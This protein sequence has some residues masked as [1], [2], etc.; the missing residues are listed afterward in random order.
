MMSIRFWTLPSNRADGSCS[1]AFSN[2]SCPWFWLDPIDL[3]VHH[4]LENED[5]FMC[6][7]F[8]DFG[9]FCSE[10]SPRQRSPLT[11]MLYMIAMPI[12]SSEQHIPLSES[13]LREF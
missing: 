4:N 13:K 1:N 2:K 5:A 9:A 8:G 12:S 10:A 11:T 7:N 3:T 6:G